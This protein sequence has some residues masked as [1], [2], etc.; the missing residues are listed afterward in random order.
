MFSLHLKIYDPLD[1]GSFLD[2]ETYIYR[3]FYLKSIWSLEQGWFLDHQ[4]YKYYIYN[5]IYQK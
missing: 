3:E 1:Q 4:T 2:R 5:L